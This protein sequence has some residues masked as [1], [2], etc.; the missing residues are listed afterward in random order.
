MPD[1]PHAGPNS[2][3][4]LKA[5]KTT[6]T[7]IFC[8]AETLVWL[9]SIK[10]AR[11]VLFRIHTD[12]YDPPT[13]C[14]RVRAKAGRRLALVLFRGDGA[15]PA[16]RWRQRHCLVRGLKIRFG[17]RRIWRATWAGVSGPRR[18]LG[19]SSPRIWIRSAGRSRLGDVY[20]R[21]ASSLC[22]RLAVFDP[23]GRSGRV[24][25]SWRGE[26]DERRWAGYTGF[27]RQLPRWTMRRR[28]F[29]A[30]AARA[31]LGG[32]AVRHQ[33]ENRGDLCHGD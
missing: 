22:H 17:P 10:P 30:F 5:T 31:R 9:I 28:A 14:G 24:A 1:T 33:C 32:G 13:H 11:S 29:F 3:V 15:G 12:E 21:S 25:R 6:I 2:W 23:L 16:G 18:I 4:G 7:P 19:I 20:P 27:D 8:Y 26:W